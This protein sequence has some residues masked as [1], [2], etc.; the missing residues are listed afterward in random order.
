MMAAN[1]EKYE[2]LV[3]AKLADIDF[4][5]NEKHSDPRDEINE[6]HSDRATKI[7]MATNK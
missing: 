1:I 5:I 4:Q 2:T 6:K 3:K 7:S